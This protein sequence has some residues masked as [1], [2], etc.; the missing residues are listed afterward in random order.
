MCFHWR[1]GVLL[2][3]FCAAL[4]SWDASELCAQTTNPPIATPSNVIK[5]SR[6][7][8]VEGAV[9]VLLMAAAGYAVCRSSRRV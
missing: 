8:Y 4:C 9:V 7:Y 6:P 2:T 5:Q 3:L 1:R